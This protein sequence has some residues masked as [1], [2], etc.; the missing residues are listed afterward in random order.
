MSSLRKRSDGQLEEERY[1]PSAC[2]LNTSPAAEDLLREHENCMRTACELLED[3]GTDDRRAVA[4]GLHRAAAA[5]HTWLTRVSSQRHA[6]KLVQPALLASVR[7]P[8]LT[9][10]AAVPQ[11]I[12]KTGVLSELQ[13]E[14]LL[15]AGQCHSRPLRPSGT[16]HG[17]LLADGAGVGKGR[18]QAAI[19]LDAWLQG[20]QKALWVSASADLL[21]DAKRD[22]E[23][24]STS[25]AGLPRLDTMLT[26][27]TQVPLSDVIKM[28]RGVLFASYALLARP[29]RLA[30]VL[31]WCQ[32]RKPFQGVLSL[33][34]SHRAKAAGSTGAGAAVLKLQAEMPLARVV[35]ASATSATE[36]HNMQYLIRLGLWGAGTPY[37]SFNDFRDEM[38]AGGAAAKELLPLH[39]KM[40]GA[41]VSRQLSYDGVT[42]MVSTHRLTAEQRTGCAL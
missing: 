30:Q 21:A 27:L 16:R 36:I 37:A 14:A 6:D 15:Y 20:H 17:F 12:G 42:V 38:Q 1:R 33:D 18:T 26:A 41:L 4:A 29:G 22:L 35:Y 5:G 23:A 8:A 24:V 40:C 32:A 19:I 10:V 31:A 39:L 13:L 34:E 7:P 28:P 25:M 3:P 9:Y 2:H 11:Q